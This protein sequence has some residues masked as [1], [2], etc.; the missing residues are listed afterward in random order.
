MIDR[1]LV[2]TLASNIF[3]IISEIVNFYLKF[4]RILFASHKILY[5]ICSSQY[6]GRMRHYRGNGKISRIYYTAATFL[7]T[8]IFF[9]IIVC[10]KPGTD[11]RRGKP[12]L[13][14]CDARCRFNYVYCFTRGGKLRTNPDVRSAASFWWTDS[15]WIGS[16]TALR[17]IASCHTTCTYVHSCTAC[18]IS[19]ASV[20]CAAQVCSQLYIKIV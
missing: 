19:V 14:R 10:F 12:N 18:R 9:F 13:P 15:R 1:H 11:L 5:K 6:F 8:Y 20:R 4:H 3:V 16:C 17:Q 2:A 7:V